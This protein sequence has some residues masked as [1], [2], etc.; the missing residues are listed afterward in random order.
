MTKRRADRATCGLPKEL[1]GVGRRRQ[2]RSPAT[3]CLQFLLAPSWGSPRQQP[4]FCP[5]FCPSEVI[6]GTLRAPDMTIEERIGL[7]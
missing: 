1:N 2:S 4:N 7:R 3:R 6:L 5:T